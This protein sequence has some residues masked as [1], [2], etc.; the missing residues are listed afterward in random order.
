MHGD[1]AFGGFAGREEGLEDG[2]G[3]DGAVEVVELE[4]LEA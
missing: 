4:V 3:G 2:V 1:G